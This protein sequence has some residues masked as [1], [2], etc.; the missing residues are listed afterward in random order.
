MEKE[1][2]PKLLT[3]IC[4]D[5]I[6]LLERG[7]QVP[8]DAR[9]VVVEDLRGAEVLAEREILLRGRRDH[10]YA[11]GHGELHG[12]TADRRRRAPDQ[13]CLVAGAALDVVPRE[14]QREVLA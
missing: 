14:W 4:T 8:H 12:D 11:R 7:R 1:R 3:V 6:I 5:Q 9:G 13:Q 2:G 10:L